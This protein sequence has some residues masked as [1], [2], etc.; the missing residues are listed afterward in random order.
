MKD[1]IPA[2]VFFL[3]LAYFELL[4]TSSYFCFYDK[5]YVL[6]FSLNIKAQLLGQWLDS[7]TLTELWLNFWTDFVDTCVGFLLWLK[8]DCFEIFMQVFDCLEQEWLQS[9]IYYSML[10]FVIGL[11]EWWMCS[12]LRLDLFGFWKFLRFLVIRI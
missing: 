4:S 8:W 11:V 10:Y 7:I 5:K 1:F 12:F 6:D 3:L 2:E 9:Y